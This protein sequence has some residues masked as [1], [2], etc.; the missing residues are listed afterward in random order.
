RS[1]KAQREQEQEQAKATR[2]SGSS[3][4]DADK[5]KV[6]Q[7]PPRSRI[8]RRGKNYRKAA[9]QIDK[10]KEYTLRE[11]VALATKTN[12]VKFDAT[13]ELHIK[14]G[15]DPRQADQNI[16]DVVALPA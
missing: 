9:E 3:E 13:V 14:L 1:A 7:K 12:P 8:E 10:T 15:V 4:T 2:K 11:A 5:P 6:Q 16:R